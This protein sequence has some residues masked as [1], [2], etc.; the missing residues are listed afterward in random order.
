MLTLRENRLTK[1][2]RRCVCIFAA[3]AIVD[4]AAAAVQWCDVDDDVYN[5]W[6]R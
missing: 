5:Q 3:T 1:R 6:Y 4:A 2:E